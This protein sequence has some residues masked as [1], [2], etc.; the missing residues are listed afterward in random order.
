MEYSVE[1]NAQYVRYFCIACP[2]VSTV[3]L[4]SLGIEHGGTRGS[5]ALTGRTSIVIARTDPIKPC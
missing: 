1:V 2:V 3:Y 5:T 4:T